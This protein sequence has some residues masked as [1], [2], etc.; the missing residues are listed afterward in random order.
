MIPHLHPHPHY[1]RAFDGLSAA[2]A[3]HVIELLG[4]AVPG[5]PRCDSL[6]RL[7]TAKQGVGRGGAGFAPPSVRAQGVFTLA[8]Q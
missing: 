4:A 3:Q 5:E 1:C 6:L 7:S 2:E 8:W